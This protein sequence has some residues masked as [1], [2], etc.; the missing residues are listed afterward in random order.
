MHP[1]NAIVR[2]LDEFFAPEIWNPASDYLPNLAISDLDAEAREWHDVVNGLASTR[3]FFDAPPSVIALDDQRIRIRVPGAGYHR[4]ETDLDVDILPDP[5]LNAAVRLEVDASAR[6]PVLRFDINADFSWDAPWYLLLTG[7]GAAQL[8]AAKRVF[9]ELAEGRL[10]GF[11]EDH[12]RERLKGLTT[13]R[14]S[15]QHDL[16]WAT[17]AGRPVDGLFSADFQGSR[18]PAARGYVDIVLVADGYDASDIGDFTGLAEHVRAH[19]ANSLRPS[20][21]EPFIAYRSAIRIWRMSL[22]AQDTTDPLQRVVRPIVTYQGNMVNFTNLARLAEIGLTLQE[23]FGHHPILVVASQMSDA[24]RAAVDIDPGASI[25]SNTQG[26]YVLL[27]VDPRDIARF[28]PYAQEATGTLVHELGHTPLGHFLT[29]E[30]SEGYERYRGPEPAARNV[31]TQRILGWSKWQP[32]SGELGDVRAFEGAYYHDRGVFRFQD[33]CRMRSTHEGGFCPV[34]RE[35]LALGL[36]KQGHERA[37]T[38]AQRGMID[39]AVNTLWPWS[40][41][42][43]QVLHLEGGAEIHLEVF[44]DGTESTPKTQVELQV[45]GSSVPQS[46]DPQGQHQAL[47]GGRPSASAPPREWHWLVTWRR[48]S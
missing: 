38:A 34:C 5:E 18:N 46:S 2:Y 16:V 36:L 40:D 35:E 19:F 4:L 8:Y 12:M 1:T 15:R 26:P 28:S 11:I 29:D 13:C 39:L 31:S 47:Y 10:E 24:D 33:E 23:T 25:R 44:S 43:P 21:E 9:E 20:L 6:A 3:A 22:T 30:Y 17:G 45:T 27:S 7:V 42:Q 14:F 32:W 37:G 41:P 48:Y